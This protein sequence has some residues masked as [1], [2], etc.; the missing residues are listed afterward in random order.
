[1]SRPTILTAATNQI[2]VADCLIWLTLYTV[3]LNV[4]IYVGGYPIV[5]WNFPLSIRTSRMFLL[6]ARTTEI[7]TPTFH[8]HSPM[9]RLA[10]IWTWSPYDTSRR[11]SSNNDIACV[12]NL[13]NT[14]SIEGKR[15]SSMAAK[16]FMLTKRPYYGV[17]NIF[18]YRNVPYIHNG[19]LHLYC[20]FGFKGSARPAAFRGQN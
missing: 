1:M 11:P 10:T 16:R 18:H 15:E 2:N 4:S 3:R 19:S 17:H 13:L 9:T 6:Y 20:N 14:L 7:R 5:F 12:L 8:R